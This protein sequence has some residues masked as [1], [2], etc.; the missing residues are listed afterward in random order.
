MLVHSVA[1]EAVDTIAKLT[2]E[3]A[4]LKSDVQSEK[5]KVSL[6]Y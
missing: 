6:N 2:G 4:N 5:N 1:A 3:V